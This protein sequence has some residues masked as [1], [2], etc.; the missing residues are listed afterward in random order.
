MDVRPFSLRSEMA[1]G[2]IDTSDM[3]NDIRNELL[4]MVVGSSSDDSDSDVSM[5][6]FD[7]DNED[8]ID[9]PKPKLSRIA[10]PKR[11]QE[12][13]TWQMR[14]L[15]AEQ[16]AILK[17]DPTHRDTKEF[18]G[19]FRLD[20]VAFERLVALFLDREWCNAE[21]RDAA[22][23]RCSSIELLILG[24]LCTLAHGAS[25][26]FV[27]SNT[28]I[29]KEV[30]RK[31]FKSFIHSM[32]SVEGE[33][34]RMPS[35]VGELSEVLTEHTALGLP[36]CVGS[37][38][39][40]HVGWD[41]C[42]A[43]QLHLFKGKEGYPSIAYEVIVDLM[44]RIRHV[45]DGHP[46][47]RNDKHIC[48][49]DDAITRLLNGD[50]VLGEKKWQARNGRGEVV[51]DK[52]LYL[53]CDGGYH[54][55]PIMICPIQH[56]ERYKVLSRIITGVRKDVEDV[57]GIMK[58]RFGCLKHWTLLKKQRDIDAMFV[59]C[60]ILHNIQTEADGY[61]CPDLPACVNSSLKWCRRSNKGD[62]L[63]RQDA[64]QQYDENHVDN[65]STSLERR[66]AKRMA[67]LKDHAIHHIASSN[68]NTNSNRNNWQLMVS[69]LQT[70]IASPLFELRHLR[71][72][73]LA[74]RQTPCF[75]TWTRL[76]NA[77]FGHS[78][79][80]TIREIASDVGR[81]SC[82]W[83]NQAKAQSKPMW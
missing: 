37:V 77:S 27:Q 58:K 32:A 39:V 67:L 45:T 44:K 26:W 20:F 1:D 65:P 81:V 14:H 4:D 42:P 51:L 55:W 9:P 13:A 33:F 5:R 50:S 15:T 17:T 40:V 24:A 11:K 82:L 80:P 71:K 12:E 78:T 49:L 60:C 47:A 57:F 73:I 61:F 6:S 36:G 19:L 76:P 16:R 79:P 21:R 70:P 23:R 22:G 53:I 31:F 18:K 2:V 29:D 30:H 63:W 64:Q 66:W 69:H 7:G 72:V 83:Q 75:A 3:P 48:R 68:R 46:G 25:R 34:I 74:K 35:R 38:D 8:V 56:S 28:N 52:G 62:G 41:A 10:Y 54:R 43:N 59:T